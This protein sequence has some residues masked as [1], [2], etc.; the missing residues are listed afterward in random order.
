MGTSTGSVTLTDVF[1]I[2]R[3]DIG[4][5]LN[6]DGN[7][8]IWVADSLMGAEHNGVL[9]FTNSA[10][11]AD[12]VVGAKVTVRGTVSEFDISV[13]SAPPVGDKLTEITDPTITFVAAPASPPT[14]ATTASATVL[15]DIGAVGEP[16]EGVLVQLTNV[17]VTNINVGQGKVEL[18][19][20]TGGKI[21]M[22]DEAFRFDAQ[23]VDTC[24]TL[25]GIMSIQLSDNLRTINPRS[26]ADMAAATGCN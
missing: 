16:W 9:V 1:V 8:G 15:A 17:K 26:V 23:T 13:N 11:A 14:P 7:K 3:D 2:G 5:T 4:T 25:T 22:D 20:T 6:P 10:A 19:D 21:I 12:L 18:T 24:Y